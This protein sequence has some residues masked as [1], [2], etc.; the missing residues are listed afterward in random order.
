M[1]LLGS[2]RGLRS[3]IVG[4]AAGG[5]WVSAFS[6]DGL[7]RLAGVATDILPR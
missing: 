1:V 2:V 6:V 3:C 4:L 7:S 5:I